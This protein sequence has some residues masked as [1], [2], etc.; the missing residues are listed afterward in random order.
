MVMLERLRQRGLGLVEVIV[1]IA[2][3]GMVVT[4]LTGLGALVIRVSV[5]NER[6][7]VALA[8][9]SEKMEELRAA[10]YDEVGLVDGDGVI[11]PAG[12]F[13]REEI[14]TRNDQQ[15]V[16]TLAMRYVDDPSDGPATG[17][18]GC[19]NVAHYP[20]GGSGDCSDICVDQE[21]L[22]DHLNHGDPF[23]ERCDGSPFENDYKEVAVGVTWEK[24]EEGS[25]LGRVELASFI[26]PP[27]VQVLFPPDQPP[28]PGE[29]CDASQVCSNELI[30]EAESLTCPD[31]PGPGDVCEPEE[32]CSNNLTCPVSGVCPDLP[33]PGDVCE[34]EERCTSGDFCSVEG[35]CPDLPGPNEPCMPPVE[36]CTVSSCDPTQQCSSGVCLPEG[37]C[38][39]D[40]SESPLPYPDP[41]S[42]IPDAGNSCSFEESVLLCLEE[43]LSLEGPRYQ[44]D[45]GKGRELVYWEDS[46]LRAQIQ[47]AANTCGA[48]MLDKDNFVSV[49]LE[50]LVQAVSS[51]YRDVM[52]TGDCNVETID[53][54][55]NAGHKIS[56]PDV[57]EL[58]ANGSCSQSMLQYKVNFFADANGHR[59]PIPYPYTNGVSI[60]GIGDG[61][62]HSFVALVCSDEEPTPTPSEEPT[63][64]FEP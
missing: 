12:S 55:R 61:N 27:G 30:C 29:P 24:P 37:I 8:V 15:Y 34:P 20:P 44:T 35:L 6:K 13:L 46:A 11:E 21:D 64:T 10:A 9:A 50:S 4:S 5:Q 54:Y 33:G 49:N 47:E 23:A 18:G 26:A 16:L 59:A 60:N 31:L 62:D 52:L 45:S 3:L 51:Y 48:E 14:V 56:E 22:Q 17:A 53:D 39:L 41:P 40:P 1:A 43:Q 25:A 63:F 38:P 36:V 19:Y 58:Y 7:T 57:A 42:Y 32:L 28:G 2:V